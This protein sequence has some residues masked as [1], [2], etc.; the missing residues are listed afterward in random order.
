M[1]RLTHHLRHYLP[2]F[3]I[4]CAGILGFILFPYDK[5]FLA[6]L[7]LA[8]SFGYLS[9]GVVHHYIHKDLHTS[10]VIEYAIIALLGIVIVFSVLFRA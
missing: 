5:N 2:L 7:T 4:L 3:G 8:T 1:K 9:W 6:A 10:V